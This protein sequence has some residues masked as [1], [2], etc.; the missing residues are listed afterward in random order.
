MR[1]GSHPRYFSITPTLIKAL[2]T[3]E[4]HG[5]MRFQELH[6]IVTGGNAGSF[7]QRLQ[8]WARLGFVER[9]EIKKYYEVH[10]SLTFKGRALLRA[11]EH[12]ER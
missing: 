1:G 11:V 9:L 4:E 2:K 3:L 6:R 12:L 7:S 10:Y 5:A 8:K